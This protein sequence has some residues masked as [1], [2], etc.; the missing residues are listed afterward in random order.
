MGDETKPLIGSKWIILVGGLAI[1]AITLFGVLDSPGEMI[2]SDVRLGPV[3]AASKIIIPIFVIIGLIYYLASIKVCRTCGR[4][5]FWKKESEP[6][7]CHDPDC[8]DP[9]CR[10][11]LGHPHAYQDEHHTDAH[12][13]SGLPHAHAGEHLIHHPGTEQ[14]KVNTPL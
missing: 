9:N 14:T 11:T 6:L 4:I 3:I 13:V 1:M 7:D 8:Q 10:P 2:R 5:L 12:P